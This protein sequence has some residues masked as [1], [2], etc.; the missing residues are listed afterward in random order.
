[1]ISY[2]VRSGS[3]TLDSYIHEHDVRIQADIFISYLYRCWRPM[4]TPT[5]FI[6]SGS[7]HRELTSQEWDRCGCT[8]PCPSM[9]SHNLLLQKFLR[10]MAFSFLPTRRPKLGSSHRNYCYEIIIIVNSFLNNRN[11]K[12]IILFRYFVISLLI[13]IYYYHH[14]F[15]T[16]T[17]YK[18]PT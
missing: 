10:C 2:A 5:V 9:V 13:F 4:L 6:V 14:H 11:R 15:S 1:M 3:R 12:I 17:V 7:L 8:P 18:L 16:P